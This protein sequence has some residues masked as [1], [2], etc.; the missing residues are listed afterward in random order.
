MIYKIINPDDKKSGVT[1]D[2]LQAKQGDKP[3]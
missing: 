1:K 2:R 3:F